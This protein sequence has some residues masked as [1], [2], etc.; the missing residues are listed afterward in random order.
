MVQGFSSVPQSPS[1]AEAE[2]AM[3]QLASRMGS[4]S[5]Q[6][7]LQPQPPQQSPFAGADRSLPPHSLTCIYVAII[8][9]LQIF[10]R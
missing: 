8:K 10:C 4:L 1:A 7:A 3:W 5:M 9:Q 2:L 6:Q